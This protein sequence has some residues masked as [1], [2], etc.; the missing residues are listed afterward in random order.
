MSRKI[1]KINYDP[2]K[3]GDIVVTGGSGLF[4]YGIKWVTSGFKSRHKKNIPTHVGIVIEW[5]GQ[6]FIAEMLS[7]GFSLNPFSRYTGEESKRKWIV[8][9]VSNKNLNPAN[10]NKIN[11]EL[12]MMYRRR[13]EKK[14]DWRGVFSFVSNR[15]KQSSDKEFCSEMASFLWE[16][17]ADVKI[18]F[19]SSSIAP[20][21]F[22]VDSK[23][24]DGIVGVDWKE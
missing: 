6:K 17:Y 24:I 20:V 14:Y 13:L 22:N 9:I 4:G 19:P 7:K 21:H 1:Q 3:T 8:D 2:I 5:G 10:R 15:V 16:T 18:N 11:L 23:E 12:A